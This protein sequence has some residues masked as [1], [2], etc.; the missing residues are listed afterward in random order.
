MIKKQLKKQSFQEN[1]NIL[2][3]GTCDSHT[4]HKNYKPQMKIQ[5]IQMY[6]QCLESQKCGFHN[7]LIVKDSHKLIK[8]RKKQLRWKIRQKYEQIILRK[9]NPVDNPI[10]YEEQLTNV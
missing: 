10:T 7:T 8:E 3:I 9:G 6:L 4:K 2:A 5:I 1:Y